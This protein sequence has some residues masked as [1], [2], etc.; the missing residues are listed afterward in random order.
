MDSQISYRTRYLA[1]PALAP[2]RDLVALEPFNPRA[3]AWQTL[4]LA[5]H[6]AALPTLRA[7]G[8]P[9]EPRRIADALVAQLKPLTGDMLTMDHIADA[10]RRL[11]ALSDAIGQRYFLQL[12]KTESAEILA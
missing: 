5:E 2:V 11:L 10:E 8:M 9:E 3:L 6:V 1:G 7:D 12:R 4:R